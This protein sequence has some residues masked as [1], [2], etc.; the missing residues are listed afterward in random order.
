MKNMRKGLAKFGQRL[1]LLSEV[2]GMI[3]VYSMDYL[4]RWKA[5]DSQPSDGIAVHLTVKAKS[6]NPMAIKRAGS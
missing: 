1:G 4:H 2:I 5:L 3:K 6:W